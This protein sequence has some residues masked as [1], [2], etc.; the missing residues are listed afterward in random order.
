MERQVDMIDLPEHFE[1]LIGRVYN[2]TKHGRRLQKMS[3]R[4]EFRRRLKEVEALRKERPDEAESRLW[5]ANQ[6]A[7]DIVS[8]KETR[9]DVFERFK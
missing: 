5:V 9:F 8:G 2:E 4:G 1:S 7:R 3:V 6:L